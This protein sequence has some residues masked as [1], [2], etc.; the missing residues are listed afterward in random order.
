M[1]LN[2]NFYAITAFCLL[3][4]QALHSQSL[5]QIYDLAKT[6]DL[7]YQANIAQFNAN[8]EIEAISRAGLL[9]QISGNASFSAAETDT[10]T[11]PSN[12]TSSPSDGTA[13]ADS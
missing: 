7:Q 8:K 9:P 13:T 5:T 11:S 1:K 6:N 12:A 4:A 3:N 10:S 2:F